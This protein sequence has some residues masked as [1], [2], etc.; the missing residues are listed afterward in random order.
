MK[1]FNI[2]F[3]VELLSPYT[4]HWTSFLL[5]GHIKRTL[6]KDYQFKIV[7]DTS[8][9]MRGFKR[10]ME[11]MEIVTE[12]YPEQ[13]SMRL[14]ECI[15]DWMQEHECATN[16]STGLH[17]NIS[18]ADS[19]L[20]VDPL[21]LLANLEDYHIA[22][23]FRRECNSFCLPWEHYVRMLM[24]HVTGKYYAHNQIKDNM[25][26]L[27]YFR[28]NLYELIRVS[29][30]PD[31]ANESD[32]YRPANNMYHEKLQP[33][34]ASVNFVKLLDGYLE[35]RMIGGKDYHLYDYQEIV[36]HLKTA[37]IRSTKLSNRRVISKWLTRLFPN[38]SMT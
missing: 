2:G 14:L 36:D 11:C 37:M 24:R 8:L 35:F 12:P 33:K 38:H 16:S 17:I 25:S 29:C 21:I 27:D 5:K 7:E 32:F 19:P 15:F 26:L 34:Y 3:E 10:H 9:N 1:G 6:R 18:F 13:E 22:Q 30:H 28:A 20:Y 4:M 23:Q 31:Q